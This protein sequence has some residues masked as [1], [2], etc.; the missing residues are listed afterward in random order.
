LRVCRWEKVLGIVREL[1]SETEE[2]TKGQ[3]E[4]E[5]S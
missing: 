3:N 4:L 5:N 2:G 1:L